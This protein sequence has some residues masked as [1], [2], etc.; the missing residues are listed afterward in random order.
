MSIYPVRLAEWFPYGDEMHE[1][2]ISIVKYCRCYGC[3]K[4]VR[5][6]AAVGHHSL[7]WGHGD[8]WCSW[9]CCE[10]G[11]VAKEDKRRQRRLDRKFK[12]FE[13]ILSKNANE[14]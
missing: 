10:K 1:N 8:L 12:N 4:K 14:N 7:P 13:I 9:K 5:W 11:K 2:A 6:K 3:G